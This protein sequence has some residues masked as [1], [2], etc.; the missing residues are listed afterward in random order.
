MADIRG[1]VNTEV[2]NETSCPGNQEQQACLAN[3]EEL[4]SSTAESGLPIGW[5]TIHR[6]AA[7]QAR[8]NWLDKRGILSS[9]GNSGWQATVILI[10]FLVTIAVLILDATLVQDTN[11]V[12]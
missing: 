9:H 12:W 1:A 4:L 5:G 11:Q 8:C 3:L 10:G 2:V 6:C 7:R